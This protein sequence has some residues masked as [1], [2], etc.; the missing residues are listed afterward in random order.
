MTTALARN[1]GLERDLEIIEAIAAV[2]PRA[3]RNGDI[4]EATNREKSQVS[5]AVSRLI[6]NGLLLRRGSGVVVGPRLYAIARYTFEAHLVN[7]ARGEMHGLV[8]KFGETI[9]LTVLQGLEVITIH[10]ESPAHGFR[11]L[12]WMGVAAPA[13][14]T[15]SGRVLL[16][17]LDDAQIARLFPLDKEIVGAPIFCKTKN[18]QEL[19]EAIRKIRKDGYATVIEE[20]EPGLIGASVPIHDYS[21]SI[22]AAINV[23]APRARF[24]EHL[25]PAALEMKKAAERI[26][27]VISS[28]TKLQT[29]AKV[30]AKTV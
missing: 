25:I 30:K 16:S 11:A 6:D 9:H 22:I 10:S 18:G 26:S 23:A 3:M 7:A 4:A 8:H 20:Y 29:S 17:G 1:N 12:S 13:Y 2:S 21:G 24:E 28:N 15:S 14:M 5:R 19:I 27:S